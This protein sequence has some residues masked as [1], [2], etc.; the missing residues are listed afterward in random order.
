VDQVH[1]VEEDGAAGGGQGHGPL[2]VMVHGVLD[3][4][5][6]FAR[7]ARRL[8]AEGV[9]SIRYDRRGYGRSQALGAGDFD[10]H[11]ADLLG[12]LDGRPATLVGHSYGGVLALAA[13]QTAPSLV[14]S[15]LAYEAPMAWVSW[16]PRTSAGSE[17]LAGHL[18]DGGGDPGDA[19]EAFMRRMIGDDRWERLPIGTRRMRRA[20]GPALLAELRSMRRTEPP[21]VAGEIGCPV[22]GGCGTRSAAHHQRAAGELAAAVPDGRLEVVEGADH[23]V[24]LTHAT[25]F[26]RLIHAV[27]TGTATPGDGPSSG[28]TA[29]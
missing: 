5:A 21:Y 4:G 10:D 11:V 24:H 1:V 16:W 25:E 18:A 26:A 6:S 20:E 3:R 2:V 9:R 12:V 19:A 29:V 15:V 28:R 13:A 7:T 23:G 17:A 8:R 22:V 14:R 27:T